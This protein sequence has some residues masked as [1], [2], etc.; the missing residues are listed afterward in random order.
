MRGVNERNWIWHIGAPLVRAVMAIAFRVQVIGIDRIP[1][2]GQ[3]IIAPNHVSMLD[4]PMIS[5]T[6]G[7][8]GG[9]VTRNLIA[10]EMFRGVKGWIL[11]KAR[12]IPIRRGEGDSHALDE[13][14]AA[15]REGGCVGI[16]PEGRVSEDATSGLQRIRSGITRVA[17]PT[18]AP[19][20]PVGIWGTQ[21]TYP[22]GEVR[23]TQLLRRPR[24]GIV[25]GDPLVP[26]ADEEP[27]AF[28]D[29]LRDALD[30]QIRRARVAAGDR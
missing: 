22:R 23:W 5:A 6:V 1:S 28:R 20:V 15:L 2:T 27:D 26:S 9:R 14:L 3:A 29:R 13:A 11:R 30:V 7:T 12:Q 24:I 16:F 18:E 4:G 19:V 8:I 10:A 17:F 21:T 25:F